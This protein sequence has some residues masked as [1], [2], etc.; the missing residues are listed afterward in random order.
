M[1][2]L[3]LTIMR[4]TF[5]K[6]G[7]FVKHKD[8]IGVTLVAS[9]NDAYINYFDEYGDHCVVNAQDISYPEDVELKNEL[10]FNQNLRELA[11]HNDLIA[12]DHNS[13]GFLKLITKASSFCVSLVLAKA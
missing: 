8:K 2:T 13:D 1:Y 10:L 11:L 4:I 12:I 9:N 6:P 3:S 5:I 7:A